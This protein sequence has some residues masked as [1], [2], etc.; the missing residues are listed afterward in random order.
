MG[1][2]PRATPTRRRA[3]VPRSDVN[4]EQSLGGDSLLYYSIFRLIDGYECTSGFSS[5]SETEEEFT[6]LM[7]ERI[8]AELQEDDPWME[9]ATSQ[10]YIPRKDEEHNEH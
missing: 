3:V 8:D 1:R 5:G 9:L 10:N 7:R 6:Q 2:H 4:R